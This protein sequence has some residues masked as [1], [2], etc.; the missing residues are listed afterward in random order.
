MLRSALVLFSALAA[1]AAAQPPLPDPT[2]PGMAQE[3]PDT[4]AAQS[5]ELASALLRNGRTDEATAL[6][7][8]LYQDDPAS[9]ALWLKLK[10]AY[11]AGRRYDALVTLVDG[12]IARSGP[13]LDL[14]AE[15]GEAL[16]RAGREA[17]AAASWDAAIALAPD[18]PQSYRQVSNAVGGLRLFDRAAQILEAGVERLGDDGAFLLERAHLYGLALDYGRAAE[19]YLALLADQPE[20][21]PTV[22][23][24]LTRLLS[25]QGA[26]DVFATAIARAAALDPLNRSVRELQAWLGLELG[27]YDAALDAVR[28]LDRLES[29][30]GESLL[31]FAGQ[32]D[33][34]GA[35]QAAARALDE[36][37]ERHADGPHAADALLA[38]ARLWDQTARADRERAQAGPTPNADAAR[39]AYAR[40]V[41]TYPASAAV[42]AASLA[43]ADLLRDVF[44]DFDE[45]EARLSAAASG[46]DAGVAARARLALGDVA[47]RRGDLDTARQ[48]FQDVDETIRIGPLAEEARYELALLDF[49]EGFMYSALA[50]AEAQDENTA[51]DAANDAISLRVTLN[52]TLA[53]E[54]VLDPEIDVSGQPL[55]VYARAALA[56][57]RGLPREAIA[58]LDSLDAAAGGVHALGDESLYLRASALFADGRAEDAVAVLD[59]LQEFYPSSFFFDR[60]LR[61]QARAYESDLGDPGSAAER[62]DLLLDRFPGSPLAPEA[63]VELRRLRALAPAAS[64]A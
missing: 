36:I 51:A 62:Y 59:R 9:T 34:A 57:R 48:R 39:Q 58:V 13:S 20:Y 43:L 8:D 35:P 1:A 24:R 32:A 12:R 56:H 10:E 28:A 61:L 50:R 52:E 38:R 40:Y 54:P 31:A 3:P 2:R 7:E 37:L 63:R 15:R 27:D 25:G 45:S 19:L 22:Q 30:R 17:E 64:G 4:P 21:R 42:P 26:A 16:F 29:E 18:D 14:L 6:L 33:A 44:R 46:R 53:P 47:L 5:F 60:S 41:E 23:A 49:Y 55:W 11:L